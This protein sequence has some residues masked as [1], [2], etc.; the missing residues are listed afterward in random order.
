MGRLSKKVL[1]GVGLVLGEL[2]RFLEVG[3]CYALDAVVK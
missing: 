1:E 3:L 2:R